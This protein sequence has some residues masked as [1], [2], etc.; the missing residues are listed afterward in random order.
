MASPG[1]SFPARGAQPDAAEVSKG[2]PLY[3]GRLP[4]RPPNQY[5][6]LLAFRPEKLS[7]DADAVLATLLATTTPLFSFVVDT[8]LVT[9]M[10][11]DSMLNALLLLLQL[12]KLRHQGLLGQAFLSDVGLAEVLGPVPPAGHV[13]QR[14]YKWWFTG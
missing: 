12:H 6:A 4:Q 11:Q 8:R 2:M 1:W 9:L 7:K 3:L 10:G 13:P 14:V 5:S